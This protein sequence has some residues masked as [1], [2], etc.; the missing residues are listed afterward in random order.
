MG[1]RGEPDRRAAPRD[2][3]P[4]GVPRLRDPGL[5]REPGARAARGDGAADEPPVRDPRGGRG[6]TGGARLP[7]ARRACAAGRRD[8]RRVR[9]RADHVAHRRLRGRPLAPR[10]PRRAAHAAAPALGGGGATR[11]RGTRRR[12][13]PAPRRPADRRGGRGLRH[14]C[15]EPRAVPAP[16][17]GHRPVRRRDGPRRAAPAEA[18][19]R[20]AGRLDRRGGAALP[21]APAPRRAVPRPDRLRAPRDAD[22]A[23]RHRG[24][25]PVPG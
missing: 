24:R 7:D 3:A 9:A 10:L 6:R 19:P 23:A 11:R 5:G 8:R 14:R 16:R 12:G 13:P 22:R 17:P 25:A 1:H 20:R 21:P 4:D 2:D 18:D 15:R